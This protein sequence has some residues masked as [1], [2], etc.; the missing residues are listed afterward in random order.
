MRV[1]LLCRYG[2]QGATSRVRHYQFIPHLH[3]AGIEVTVAPFFPD[4]YLD[5]LYDQE[6][7]SLRAYVRG[8]CARAAALVR[9]RRFDALWIE[10]ELFPWLPAVAE[11]LLARAGIPYIVDYDDAV[12]HRYDSDRAWLVRRLLGRK[13]DRVM[14]QAA[15]VIAGNEYIAAH[16]RAAGA[17]RIE[18]LPSVVDTARYAQAEEDDARGAAPG[19]PP[20]FTIGWIGSPITARYL[21][22]IAPV[23]A[24][25]CRE[26]GTRLRLIGA[27]T[28]APLPSVASVDRRRW[29]YDE[30]PAALQA[31]DVGIMPLSDGLWERGKCGYKLLQY[32]ACAKPVVATP[33]GVNRDIVCHGE[34]GFLATTTDEWRAALTQLRDDGALRRRMGD[35]GRRRVGADYSLAGVAPRLV[36]LFHSLQDDRARAAAAGTTS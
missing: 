34:T 22:L 23:L 36:H 6:H 32:M 5:R 29:C 27:G 17:R 16:A 28:R 3:A 31:C 14:Q 33:I 25:L 30:E 35:A 13:I 24:D 11:R 8:L 7:R 1:L 20:A 10:A 2:V 4:G 18:I 9:S 19:A 12:F 15:V 21:D 26:P